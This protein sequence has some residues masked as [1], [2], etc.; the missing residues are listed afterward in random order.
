[1]RLILLFVKNFET[2]YLNSR[3]S[4]SLHPYYKNTRWSLSAQPCLWTKTV[5]WTLTLIN[6]AFTFFV[7]V[8]FVG[9]SR[10]IRSTASSSSTFSVTGGLVFV[11]W[12]NTSLISSSVSIS[13]GSWTWTFW[14]G[15]WSG[16]L[17]GCFL[18]S[19]SFF[20]RKYKSSSSLSSLSC[21]IKLCF[22]QSIL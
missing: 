18:E 22:F 7:S 6:V 1:M 20:W 19:F 21:L 15:F 9:V 8:S 10:I 16:F 3:S 14:T 11:F 4:N 5:C 17:S 2:V 12:S 13:S